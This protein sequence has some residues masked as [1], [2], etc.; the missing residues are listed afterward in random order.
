[1]VDLLVQIWLRFTTCRSSCILSHTAGRYLAQSIRHL[2]TSRRQVSLNGLHCDSVLPHFG[3]RAFSANCKPTSK[4][5]SAHN[6]RSLNRDW[7][8]F[9]QLIPENR[10]D[11]KQPIFTN[12][13]KYAWRIYFMYVHI[14]IYIHT[15]CVVRHDYLTVFMR[16]RSLE[17]YSIWSV[18]AKIN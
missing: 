18:Q 6:L 14:Y 5:N 2:E 11:S 17:Q 12:I 7:Q 9:F 16:S 13:Y 10:L 1:M 15:Y 3:S 4:T 8:Q